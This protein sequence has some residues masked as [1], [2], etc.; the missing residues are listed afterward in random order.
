[1]KV[2]KIAVFMSVLVVGISSTAFASWWNPVTW[3]IFKKESKVV[4]QESSNIITV[5]TTTFNELTKDSSFFCNGSRYKKC[6]EG[7][8]LVCP[9]NGEDAFCEKRKIDEIKTP[10]TKEPIK[11]QIDRPV[12]TKVNIK[13]EPTVKENYN[14]L[15]TGLVDSLISTYTQYIELSKSLDDIYSERLNLTSQRR[16]FGYDFNKIGG[17]ID[18][19][20]EDYVKVYIQLQDNETLYINNLQRH[21]N[22]VINEAKANLEKLRVY[23]ET[24]QNSSYTRAQ[25]ITA[26]QELMNNYDYLDKFSK[27]LKTSSES[28]FAYVS[29]EDDASEFFSKNVSQYLN[30]LLGSAPTVITPPVQKTTIIEVPRI[31]LPRTTYCTSH[32]NGLPGDYSITC[33]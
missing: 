10:K 30:K 28:Y 16:S 19:K 33:N 6:P 7:Q 26:M 4:I 21:D 27:Y 17:G 15:V 2:I 24:V 20:L 14:Y 22:E 29:K 1:M 11:N 8:S 18:Q 31:E 9:I 3:R 23:R 32:W 13:T 5:S 25:S 12:T